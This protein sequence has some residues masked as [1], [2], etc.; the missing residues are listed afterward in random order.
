MHEISTENKGLF[1]QLRLQVRNFLPMSDIEP[2]I[3]ARIIRR[4]TAAIEGNFVAW[5]G[6]AAISARSVQGRYA[7]SENLWVEMKD[8][9]AGM[10]H[11]FAR[12]A[13]ALPDAE[14][15][16]YVDKAVGKVRSLVAEM[17]GLKN[18][19]LMAAL[20]NTSAEFIPLLEEFARKQG[21]TNLKYTIMHGEADKD[22][23]QQFSWAVEHEKPFCT[24]VNPQIKEAT[25]FAI[26]FLKT[27]FHLRT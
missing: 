17:S 19:T 23:A 4:Y 26:E 15:Y 6:A 20:E 27:I 21:S 7:A 24:D 9:H 11:D 25:N 22:H 12:A 5:M 16:E 2:V 10:L 13:H 1:S 8:D 3:A 14:D 18:L